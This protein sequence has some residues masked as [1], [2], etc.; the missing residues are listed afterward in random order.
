M[1]LPDFSHDPVAVFISQWVYNRPAAERLYPDIWAAELTE[2]LRQE[3]GLPDHACLCN[4]GVQE[5]PVH[6]EHLWDK[7]KKI[8]FRKQW[9]ERVGSHE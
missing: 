5:C 9:D 3:F 2:A 6:P 7:E 8:A 1:R 4:V